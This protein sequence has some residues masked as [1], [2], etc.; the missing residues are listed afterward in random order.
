M[1]KQ[2]NTKKIT[3]VNRVTDNKTYGTVNSSLADG[4]FYDV[5]FGLDDRIHSLRAGF[6]LPKADNAKARIIAQSYLLGV[7]Y[8][9][10]FRCTKPEGV[11][12][13]DGSELADVHLAHAYDLK[14]TH[15]LDGFYRVMLKNSTV[16]KIRVK[17]PLEEPYFRTVGEDDGNHI[18]DDMGNAGLDLVVSFGDSG[19][20]ESGFDDGI[21][22]TFNNDPNFTRTVHRNV[23]QGNLYIYLSPDEQLDLSF[24]L[25]FSK[26]YNNESG[27]NFIT[28]LVIPT[29]GKFLPSRLAQ[30]K[31]LTL[32]VN[33]QS[34][35]SQFSYVDYS[36]LPVYYEWVDADHFDIHFPSAGE[37]SYVWTK[38]IAPLDDVSSATKVTQDMVGIYDVTASSIDLYHNTNTVIGQIH[39]LDIGQTLQITEDCHCI[40]DEH[41]T[42]LW[43]EVKHASSPTLLWANV[44]S[45]ANL[46]KSSSY[47]DRLAILMDTSSLPETLEKV[48]VVSEVK[49]SGIGGIGTGYKY[50]PFDA[51][52]EQ[53]TKRDEYSFKSYA[54]ESG[55]E[56]IAHGKIVVLSRTPQVQVKVIENSID[57]WVNEPF[58]ITAE[59]AER[60]DK[61]EIGR[62]NL[63]TD[64]ECT[65]KVENGNG[66]F[67]WIEI[68]GKEIGLLDGEDILSSE[69]IAT[70]QEL[71]FMAPV[72]V[73]TDGLIS[74]NGQASLDPVSISEYYETYD[75]QRKFVVIDGNIYEVV[76]IEMLEP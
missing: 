73:N 23:E 24:S 7:K 41:D 67:M 37:T 18:T 59:D 63:Y 66:G 61:G 5:S 36:S 55:G 47:V 72:P 57:G 51:E 16:S 43:C 8:S 44:S 46:E 30:F 28:S 2:A 21:V 10:G 76:S 68:T 58:Y 19:I 62:V 3:L 14:P 75:G 6:L 20:P 26:V 52:Q 69:N 49:S 60:I 71:A 70:P 17:R 45:L 48:V 33:G 12:R 11:T 64:A 15:E 40:K 39:T 35:T 65:Q 34:V 27:E 13:E 29:A 53:R 1:S 25:G 50:I 22:L 4:N 32:N 42:L 31:S 74:N 54:V 56:E 38:N 9:D